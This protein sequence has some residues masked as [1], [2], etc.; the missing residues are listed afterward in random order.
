MQ[1]LEGWVKA[2]EESQKLQKKFSLETFRAR[3]V[4]LQRLLDFFRSLSE[5]SPQN[6]R[7]FCLHMHEKLKARSLAR[8][9]STYSSFFRFL[10][11]QTGDR[12]WRRLE[13]PKIKIPPHLPKI[14]SFDEILHLLREDLETESLDLLEFL[15]GTGCRISEAC[16]LQWKD[17]DFSRKLIRIFGK[18]R[19]ERMIPLAGPL[20]ERLRAREKVSHYVFPSPRDPQKAL[21]PRQARRFL[22]KI[23]LEKGIAKRVH[24]HLFRHSLATH[25]LDQGADLRFIQELLGHK[26]LST[27]QKYLASSRTRLIQVFDK[28]HPRA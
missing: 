15:Y 7:K 23:T 13:R 5:I 20:E 6:W 21:Q 18:G 3:R 26:S 19:K 22:R 4:D 2:F 28:C 1:S 9:H 10:E 27:T 17:V 25:L 11:E 14:L 16:G 24:P 12:R 8:A